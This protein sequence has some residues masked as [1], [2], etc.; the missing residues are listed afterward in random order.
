MA[1]QLACPAHV[2]AERVVDFDIFDPA[3]VEQDYFAAWQS[4]QRPGGPSLVWT[5]RNGGH[6]IATRGEDIRALWADG[7]RL[8]SES[9]AVTPGLGAAM[10][11]IPLQ[12][13]APEHGAFRNAVMRGFAHVH[14]VAMEPQ[15]IAVANALIDE[16][17]AH[18]EC[19]FV[20]QFAEVLP[21]DIFLTLI[22]VPR[23]DRPYLRTFGKQLDRKSVV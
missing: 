22:D 3:G 1:A 17:I 10:R 6:W 4:L 13:D 16:L 14:I 12:Q 19:E 18:G 7:A 2:P 15:V 20:E 9:L 23:A 5:I 21:I 11:L 8:S